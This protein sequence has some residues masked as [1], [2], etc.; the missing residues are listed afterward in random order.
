MGQS[1]TAAGTDDALGHYERGSST[2][3]A[4]RCDQRFGFYLYV[5]QRFDFGA[6]GDYRLCVLIHGTG[7]TP[8]VY[9]D[10]F[11]EFA[12]A[13]QAI[14]VAPLF[15]AGIIEPGELANYKFIAFHDI[16]YDHVLNGIVDEVATRFRLGE[17]RF[18]LFGYSGGGHFAHRFA[19]LHPD[20]L[21]GV[22]I[23][24]PGMVTLIDDHLPWWR[25]TADL[26]QRFG[27]RM[28]LEALRRLPIQMVIG[29]EDTETW[30]ITLS[31]GSRFWMDGANDA[32]RTRID[33]LNSLRD[34]FTAHGIAVRFDRVPGV[35][36]NG[37]AVLGAVH[38]FFSDVLG[39]THVPNDKAA[40]A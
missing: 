22:S 27:I 6:A 12:E 14:V 28:D 29:D 17:R 36:H 24:A 39:G 10:L 13:N 8:G 40:S 23:G 26:E 30:E 25:G 7:R 21:L 18:L 35:G 37:Y 20:R 1:K 19:Y 2:Y 33:R 16:R 15:P 5:P 9:R 11:A 32:G 3:F 38:D 4:A 34:N 31:P